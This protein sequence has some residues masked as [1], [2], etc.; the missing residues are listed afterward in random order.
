MS[1]SRLI[2]V[3]ILLA[4]AFTI[5]RLQKYKIPKLITRWIFTSVALIAFLFFSWISNGIVNRFAENKIYS[6]V[7]LIPYRET[8]LVLGANKNSASLVF[9]NRIDGV[10]ILYKA[11][12]IKN[13]IVSGATGPN[14]YDEASDM[15]SALVSKGGRTL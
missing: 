1:A 6:D 2:I 7:N 4:V 12:K 5:W 10:V 8:A 15:K 3:L 13:I 11:G 9:S 14:N